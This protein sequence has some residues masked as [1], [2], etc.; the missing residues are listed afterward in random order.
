M[1]FVLRHFNF[2]KNYMKNANHSGCVVSDS[3]NP[4]Y[5]VLT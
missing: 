2:I 3:S 4:T 1:K 5:Q